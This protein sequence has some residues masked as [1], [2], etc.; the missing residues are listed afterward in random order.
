MIKEERQEDADAEKMSAGPAAPVD[1]QP[2]PAPEE[3]SKDA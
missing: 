3:D 1:Q 2:A